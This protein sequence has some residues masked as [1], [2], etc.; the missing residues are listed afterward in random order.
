MQIRQ[1]QDF[2]IIVSNNLNFMAS[3]V[4]TIAF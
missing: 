2:N 4:T 1:L 3:N